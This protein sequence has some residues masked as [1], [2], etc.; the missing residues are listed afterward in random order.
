MWSFTRSLRCYG[1][2]ASCIG[3]VYVR[4]SRDAC[5]GWASGRRDGVTHRCPRPGRRAGRPANRPA[6]IYK[7]ESLL[8]AERLQSGNANFTQACTGTSGCCCCCCCCCCCRTES[9]SSAKSSAAAATA[10]RGSLD[11]CSP[12]T[13]ASASP[14]P[15]PPPP[16]SERSLSSR[17]FVVVV[18]SL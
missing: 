17:N 16:S 8:V 4:S 10:P 3:S 7:V 12:S 2:S 11:V 6:S 15:P 1:N 9:A 5:C 13:A 14:L 18:A